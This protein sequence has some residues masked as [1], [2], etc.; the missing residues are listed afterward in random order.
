MRRE[1][2]VAK[3]LFLGVDGGG[4]K[5]A[6]VLGQEDG[7]GNLVVLG[8]GTS[9]AANPQ[10]GGWETARSN[11]EACITLAFQAAR[12]PV[13]QV[14][15]CVVG[16][17]GGARDTVQLKLNEWNR[18]KRNAKHFFATNDAL[19]V[20]HAAPNARGMSSLAIS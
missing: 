6:A 17:S 8:K 1:N 3:G 9:G 4:T 5:V 15:A 18:E 2:V 7:N 13:Q 19:P 10:T 20:L 16:L 11:T 14:E 12:R